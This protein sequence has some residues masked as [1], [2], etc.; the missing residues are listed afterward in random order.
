MNRIPT[1]L[2]GAVV[3]GLVF[4][5]V[6]DV[7]VHTMW[8]LA[9]TGIPE[10]ASVTTTV[11]AAISSPLFFAAMLAFGAQL[12]NWLRVLARADLSFVQPATALSSIAVLAVSSYSL[13]ENISAAKMF[14]VALILVGVFLISRTPFHT[15][16]AARRD[17]PPPGLLPS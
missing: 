14:G 8:K 15:S 2:P 12:F 13:H 6:L 9:V 4:A 3:V 11:R 7:F 16:G 10:D 17:S 1:K 5:I